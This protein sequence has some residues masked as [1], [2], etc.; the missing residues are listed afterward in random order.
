M[1]NRTRGSANEGVI[2]LGLA[3]WLSA[4]PMLAWLML[5]FLSGDFLVSL[6]AVVAPLALLAAPLK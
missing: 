6:L 3:L 1:E 2:Y 4:A 5:W